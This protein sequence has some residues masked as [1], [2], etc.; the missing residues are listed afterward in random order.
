MATFADGLM[1]SAATWIGTAAEEVYLSAETAQAGSIGVVMVHRDYSGYYKQN[2]I[3]NTVITAG[4]Y[5]AV[6][7][8]YEPLSADSRKIIQ[9]D[10]DYVYSL[11]VDAVAKNRK[12]T[13]ARVNEDMADGRIFSGSQAVQAGLVDGIR[14]R[15]TVIQSLVE[16]GSRSR[17]G[18]EPGGVA[19]KQGGAK[20]D[21]ETLRAQHPDLV[22]ALIEEGKAQGLAEGKAAG[23]EE[24]KKLGADAERA[25]IQAVQGCSLK[26]HE[27]LVKTLMFDGKTSATEAKAMI[28]DAQKA[29]QEKTRQAF[30]NQA[31]A[32]A[33]ASENFE[34]RESE[35]EQVVTLKGEPAWRAEYAKSE[36]L[37]AQFTSEDN[38]V[39]YKKAVA[40]GK[41]RELRSRKDD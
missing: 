27:E 18:S 1:A 13:S 29:A 21:M 8:Q 31:P 14:K 34:Q 11:F 10:L 12:T 17:D 2:G 4:K 23:V 9:D 19:Q 6:G 7:N 3:K 40:E 26:G 24:G 15:E 30:E 16:R 32:A 38:Y 25:R 36:D 33:A 22:A 28:F 35:K 39:A 20:V 5:K 37:Q 41:V